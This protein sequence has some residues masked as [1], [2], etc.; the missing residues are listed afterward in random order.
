MNFSLM[1]KDGSLKYSISEQKNSMFL[2]FFRFS[3]LFS[4]RCSI[5]LTD[6]SEYYMAILTCTLVILNEI[7]HY[8]FVLSL[9][10]CCKPPA[11]IY[12]HLN[13]SLNSH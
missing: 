4:S 5:F 2:F 10:V 8:I 6:I 13:T 1:R 11:L 12:F 9:L 7:F 3:L